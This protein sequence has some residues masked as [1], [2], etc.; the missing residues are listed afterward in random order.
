MLI[1]STFCQLARGKLNVYFI[2]LQRSKLQAINCEFSKKYCV[3][4]IF[5]FK[6]SELCCHQLAE[7]SYLVSYY[8]TVG[9]IHPSKLAQISFKLSRMRVNAK[10][11][12]S[13][14]FIW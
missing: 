7:D 4:A 14:V 11:E 9:Q 10:I 6:V 2:G 8:N 1:F 13:R 5:E 3:N 12:C